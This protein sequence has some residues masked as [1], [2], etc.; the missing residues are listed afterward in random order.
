[1][2]LRKFLVSA[3]VLGAAACIAPPVNATDLPKEG[4]CKFKISSEGKQVFTIINSAQ[5]D[6]VA[7]WDENQKVIENC[8]GWPSMT[9]HC[10]G[11]NELTKGSPNAYGFCV[12]KDTDGDSIVWKVLPH[13]VD[14]KGPNPN[15]VLMASGKYAGIMGKETA[16]CKFGGSPTDYTVTCD[17]EMTYKIP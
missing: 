8:E 14:S 15:E 10:F 11:L 16:D 17:M 1:M 9:R 7:S 13:K 6:G 4:T 3:L 2:L 12:A 5:L